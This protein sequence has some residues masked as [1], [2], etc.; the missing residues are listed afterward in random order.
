[1]FGTNCNFNLFD[2]WVLGVSVAITIYLMVADNQHPPDSDAYQ[3]LRLCRIGLA[4]LIWSFG[5]GLIGVGFALVAF[6][7]GIIGVIKGRPL[8]GALLIAGAIVLPGL[9]IFYTAAKLL[10]GP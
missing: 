3:S 6:I 8:Y 4:F 9:G 2:W 1:M 7:L 10:P 5:F